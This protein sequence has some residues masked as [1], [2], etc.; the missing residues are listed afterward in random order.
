ME[1]G[2]SWL[3]C[4]KAISHRPRVFLDTTVLLKAFSATRKQFLLPAFLTDANAERLTFEKCIYE[5]YLAFR[6][7]GGK[8]PDEGRGR[9]AEQNLT[10]GVDPS[11]L[12][13]LA[14]CFHRG[15]TSRAHFW[16]NF[17]EEAAADLE[18]DEQRISKM[19]SPE[20]QPAAL[21]ELQALRELSTEASRCRQLC[22]DFYQMLEAHQVRVAAYVEVFSPSASHLET[23]NC[24]PQELDALFQSVTLPGEDFEIVYAAMRSGADLFV[25]D[26]HRLRRCS[27]SLGLNLPLSPAAFCTGAEYEEKVDAW[28][29]RQLFA[30]FA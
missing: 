3:R 12:S 20:S 29:R 2:D 14:N 7:V 5:A 25:T 16:L 22:A 6:G 1:E 4:Q 24:N 28:R 21:A 19:V 17:I 23:A 15:S 18:G 26:D 8:K 13:H 30:D 9:W 11:P 27:F 10:P